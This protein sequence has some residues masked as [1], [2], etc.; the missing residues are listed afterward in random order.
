M[1]FLHRFVFIK[2][3]IIIFISLKL[4]SCSAQDLPEILVNKE[5]IENNYLPDFSY[6]GFKNGEQEI[7][8]DGKIYAA[9][10]YGVIANDGLD[11]SKALIRAISKL[12]SVKGTV[13]LKL[14]VGKIILS[15]IIY[16]ERSDFILR[17][18][19]SGKYG[20]QLYFPRP[21]MYVPDPEPL[22]ELREY[23]LEFDKRQREKKNN[24]DLAFSQYAWSGGFIW[25]QVSGERVKSYLEKYERPVNVLAKVTSGKRGDFTVTVK[26]NSSLKVGDVTELQLFNK[27]GKEG[28]IVEELY[29]NT[30]VKVGTHHLNFPELPIVRQQL[31]ITSIDGNQVTFKTPLT[32]SIDPSYKAQIVEWKHLE[33]VGI[34]HLA[35][36]FPM[37]PRVAHHVEAGFNAINLTRLYNSWVQDVVITN[38]DSGILTEEIA[39]VTIKNITTKGDH[40]AHYTVAMAGVHNV[41]A[42]NIKVKNKA[43]HPLSFNTFSTKNVYKNC[44]VF[45]DPVLDQHSGAN[46]QNLFDNIKVYVDSQGEN[47]YPLFAGGGAGYWKPSHGAYSTFWN[48]NVKFLN[49]EQF[50]KSFTLNGMKDGPFARVIG[51]HGNHN[52][53]IEYGPDAYINLTNVSLEKAPS[54]YEYQLSRRLTQ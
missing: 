11:D 46:H 2:C 29:K 33:N 32:I 6:A 10:D 8:T 43:E 39:N 3:A 23:L 1:K 53:K 21:L 35:I 20:T 15:D 41:L 47:S 19:G 51:V 34:E 22:K 50:P 44:E 40:Y 13:I 30:D 24:I 17:G 14:P 45:V 16:I 52:I 27:D 38:A 37:T 36:E 42:E 9:T 31:E 48:I 25:T 28:K 49:P 54:L 5:V 18:S 7:P 4:N 26:N 12:R